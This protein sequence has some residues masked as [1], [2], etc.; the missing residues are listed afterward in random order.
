LTDLTLKL[1]DSSRRGEES[2]GESLYPSWGTGEW[3]RKLI[4]L[5][6]TVERL[7]SEKSDMN[8][9]LDTLLYYLTKELSA[10]KAMICLFHDDSG[11][12]FLH[13]SAGFSKEEEEILNSAIFESEESPR[14]G[15][16]GRVGF[17]GSPG[18]AGSSG[19]L[20]SPGSSGAG[21]PR[22]GNDARSFFRG[23]E[24]NKSRGAAFP[25]ENN[26]GLTLSYVPI[27][28]GTKVLG[29][30]ATLTRFP[31][32]QKQ[33]EHETHLS[34][35]SSL[36]SSAAGLYMFENIDRTFLEKKVRTLTSEIYELKERH[37]HT[38][39]VS[40]SNAMQE[41]YFL[42][43]KVASG[44]TIVLIRGERGVEKETVAQSLHYDGLKAVG[45]FIK[46]SLR[47]LKPEQIETELFGR[48]R[49]YPGPDKDTRKGLLEAA[50]GGSLFVDDI[51]KLPLAAQAK[52]LDFIRDGTFERVM[53][54]EKVAVDVRLIA[55]TEVELKDLAEGGQF[56]EDLFYRINV[57]PIT[58]PPLKA[59][60]EDIVRLA[61]HFLSR[62]SKEAGK[63]LS[64]I[65]P[66]AMDMLRSYDWPLNVRELEAVI[67]GTVIMADDK[68]AVIEPHDL[69][70]N[71]KLAS[72]KKNREA[73][74]L[75][76]RMAD[77]EHEIVSEA[78]K[79]ERGNV[80]RAAKD[81]G[82]TR[83][84]LGLRMKRL[85]LN[86]KDFRN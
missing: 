76:E 73:L 54:D 81:L 2:G 63:N 43:R 79:R 24:T 62:F 18:S 28:R 20:G 61:R 71:I 32:K 40:C 37:S 30:F 60:E 35:L 31:E 33:K 69:P 39:L 4:S 36:F 3:G 47:D 44:K 26:R 9:A 85:S 12:I 7:L 25:D 51:D 27:I 52:L 38:S 58:V 14:S 53:G 72:S 1:G 55:G 42:L 84:S 48:E 77:I 86:Y 65:S 80:S 64:A 45:P 17:P 34:F 5:F 8:G 68:A 75:D 67:H 6:L 21:D 15:W 11:K 59:R 29:A 46:T 74:G 41:V 56:L 22:D 57:F 66:P 19:S 50:D 13:R 10:L 49:R 82:I 70:L 16:R 83:R 78:L 23:F